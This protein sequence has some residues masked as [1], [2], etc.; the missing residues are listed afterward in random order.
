VDSGLSVDEAIAV[1]VRSF[2]QPDCSPGRPAEV[3]ESRGATKSRAGPPLDE[4]IV[5]RSVSDVATG[6]A[7]GRA[8]LF[9]FRRARRAGS[10]LVLHRS[11]TG[12]DVERVGNGSATGA[13]SLWCQAWAPSRRRVGHGRTLGVRERRSRIRRWSP[14]VRPIASPFGAVPRRGESRR[15]ADAPLLFEAPRG[16]SAVQ[17]RSSGLEC[18]IPVTSAPQRGH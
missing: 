12:R 14:A 16:A 17:F 3:E 11:R 4:G 18:R 5:G 6:V 8:E 2:S 13:L 10:S 7:C 15:T 1:R 9:A